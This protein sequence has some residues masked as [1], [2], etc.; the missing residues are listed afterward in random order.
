MKR[1]VLIIVGIVL[2]L[3]GLA[4]ATTGGVLAVTLG[5]DGV[6]TTGAGKVSGTGSALVFNEFSVDTKGADVTKIA[7][8]AVSARSTAGREVF[9]GLAPATQ[10]TKYLKGVPH[11]LVSDLS[12]DKAQVVPIPGT[13]APAAAPNSQT[14]WTVKAQGE[15]PQIVLPADKSQTLVI[16]NA[17]AVASVAVDLK[18]GLVSSVL[19]PFG[20]GFA[21]VGVILILLAIWVFVRAAK[22]K[23]KPPAGQM[24]PPGMYVPPPGMYVPPPGYLPPP[25]YAP[26]PTGPPQA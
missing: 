10:V 20:I 12:G 9:I 24:P 2:L 22:A 11:D 6:Y 7:S 26:P 18:I 23:R 1:A 15:D 5:S 21:V 3:L 13:T 25:Q 14:F 8:L 19:F 16:M 17:D 4:V